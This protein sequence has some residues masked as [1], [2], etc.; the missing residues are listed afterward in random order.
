M[1]TGRHPSDLHFCREVFTLTINISWQIPDRII[2]FEV[3]GHL[4]TDEIFD[5]AQE[6]VALIDSSESEKV[7]FLF[8]AD[9]LTSFTRDVFALSNAVQ[10]LMGHPRY[11]WFVLYGRD[12]PIVRFISSIVTQIFRRPSKICTTREEALRFLNEIVAGEDDID[13]STN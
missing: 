12:D 8:D 1:L 3:I 9:N 11:G 4:G 5:A 6:C 2:L 10:K 13:S 7:H